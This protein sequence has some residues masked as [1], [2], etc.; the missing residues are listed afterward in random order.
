VARI[1]IGILAL[2]P[3]L[4]PLTEVSLASKEA[5]QERLRELIDRL[6]RD[7]EAARAIGRSLPDPRILALHVTDID[8][9]YWTELADGRLGEM[10]EGEPDEPHIRIATASDDLVGFIEGGVS[11][12]SAYVSGRIR[13][14]ASFADLLRLRRLA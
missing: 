9:W 1:A 13:I 7:E 4:S 11:L 6:G 2:L 14:E 8:V 12:F 3:T 5:V 10:K